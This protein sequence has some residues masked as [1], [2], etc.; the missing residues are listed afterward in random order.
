MWSNEKIKGQIFK[1]IL[2]SRKRTKEAAQEAKKNQESIK[3]SNREWKAY[4]EGQ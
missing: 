3:R 2:C 4:G 1:N